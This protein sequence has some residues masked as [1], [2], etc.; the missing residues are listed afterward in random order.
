MLKVSASENANRFVG[1]H[2]PQEEA[3]VCAALCEVVLDHSGIA[4]SLGASA[5]SWSSQC[6]R[7]RLLSRAFRI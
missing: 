6:R 7:T 1:L 3:A 5:D 2:D 4:R